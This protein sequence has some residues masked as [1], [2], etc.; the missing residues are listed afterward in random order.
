M[1]TPDS[2][3]PTTKPPRGFVASCLMPLVTK[4]FGNLSVKWVRRWAR[5]FYYL[6]WPFTRQIRKV[7]RANL[8]IAFP[9]LGKLERNNLSKKNLQYIFELGLDWL[10]FLSHPEDASKRLIL[11]QEILERKRKFQEDATL[12]PSIHCT[13]HLGNWEL[14]SH[15]SEISGRPGA[16]IAA[17]FNTPWLNDLAEQMRTGE[18]DTLLIPAQ[19]AAW[20][21]LRAL[22]AKRDIGILIDQHIPPRK[23]GVFVKFFHL[24]VSVSPLPA[25]IAMRHRLPV[26]LLACYKR[27]DGNFTLDLESL[28]RPVT[29]YSSAVELTQDILYCYEKLIRRHPEQYL[30]LYRYWRTCPANAPQEYEERYPFYAKKHQRQTADEAIFTVPPPAAT[31]PAT[32]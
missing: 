7:I 15:I 5:F 27:D 3:Q 4:L 11:T 29:E 8:A 12:P 24:A 22:K 14:C 31:P 25:V 18:T 9:E 23:G 19:G 6:T 17:R 13:L 1:A 32:P 28:P 2:Q 26:N 21:I 30:W 20:G 16:A 10:H